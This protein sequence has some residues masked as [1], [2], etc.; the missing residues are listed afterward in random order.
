VWQCLVRLLARSD[1]VLDASLALTTLTLSYTE[2]I[3]VALA[4]GYLERQRGLIVERDRDRRDL[5]DNILQ[6]TLDRHADT[7]RLASSFALVPGGDFLVVILRGRGERIPQ[8]PQALTHA[9]ET[10]RRHFASGIAQPF[11]VVRHN[12]IVSIAPLA[13]VRAASIAHL[14]RQA[15]AEL[16]HADD[17]WIAGVS[18]SC[19]GLLEVARGYDEAR[20]A[21]ESASRQTT[22]GVCALLETRVSDYLVEHADAT[23]LRMVPVV[24]RRLFESSAASDIVLTETLREYARAEREVRVAAERLVVHPNTVAYR[25]QKLERAL[26]R[27]FSC[28]T[29]F[30]EVLTWLRLVDRARPGP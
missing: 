12:E 1:N 13:R 27:D 23:A 18:T 3:S 15:H 2:L 25:L 17:T 14:V 24:A 9:A 4:D 29:D 10:L 21:L 28:F 20:L 7:L 5:L 19:A 16:T 30:V 22:G 8:S 11:V 6:G 26:A